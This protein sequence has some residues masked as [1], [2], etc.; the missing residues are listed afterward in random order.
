MYTFFQQ[1]FVVEDIF[2]IFAELII[3][4]LNNIK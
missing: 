3:K 1:R 4:K 2:C